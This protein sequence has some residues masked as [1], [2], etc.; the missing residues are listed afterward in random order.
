MLQRL[1][2]HLYFVYAKIAEPRI[3][4][5][6]QFGIYLCLGYAG[7]DIYWHTPHSLIDSIG[8]GHVNLIG[9]FLAVGS[10]IGALTVLPGIWFLERV[11]VILVGVGLMMY[12][13][14][15]IDL[16]TSALGIAV[17][18]AFVLTFVQRFLQT[19]GRLL[20]PKKE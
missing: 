14:I 8:D 10:A 1:K 2:N 16:G 15:V 11:G 5:L 17:S 9:V 20:A 18:G 13:V 4:R 6:L 12:L 19:K 7:W 3:F